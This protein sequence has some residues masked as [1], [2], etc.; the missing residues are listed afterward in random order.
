MKKY[1]L[2]ID[3]GASGGRHILGHVENDRIITEEIYRFE[4]GADKRNG[5]LIWDTERLFDEIC[6][7]LIRC[8]EAGKIP[9]TMGIDTWGVDYVLLGKDGKALGDTYSY[10]DHRTDGMDNE[11]YKHISE[12][13]LYERTGIQ[14]QIFNTIY[15]LTADKI[16]RPEI[17]SKADTFLMLPDYFNYLLTGRK[18]SEY[19]NATTTQL[20]NAKTLEWD[21]ELLKKL[22]IK[23]DMFL[24]LQMPGTV[25]GN[26][27]REIEAK[28][29]FSCKVVL[30][31]THDTGSAVVS[32]PSTKEDTLYISSGTWSLMG[33]ETDKPICTQLSRQNN[34]TNEGGYEHRNRFQKNI[35]GLWM[36]QSL[37]H[38]L[39]DKYSFAKL[40]D[41]ALEAK[42]SGYHAFVDVNKE[43]F[44]S[45]ENMQDAIRNECEKTGQELPDN[46]SK[47][48]CVI[49][50]S[51]ADCY[52]KTLLEMEEMT[53]KKF[54][55]I[56][57]V[58]GGSNADYLNQ[59]T[60]KAMGRSVVAGPGEATAIGN[61]AVQFIAEG[62]F[63][64]LTKA[65]EAVGKSFSIKK[66]SDEIY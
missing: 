45:P 52:A 66:Y 10:R 41:M 6:N 19:T 25:V 34:F 64:S 65:R 49:Y 2:G 43:C 29:G 44:L 61:L 20:V 62:E 8:R 26:F 11:V 50:E 17:L 40:C 59:I 42:E 55:E 36:I 5:H 23:D 58:G 48:A 60:A 53:G 27:T 39:G 22:E 47:M 4:N 51:L 21:R 16:Q 38:E 32:V 31:C 33:A 14:K 18:I 15:Q 12:E 13:K 1:A 3:I 9:E 7:G 37:R 24:P 35:M 57:I 56:N 63:S 30:P 54:E 28:V 46:T